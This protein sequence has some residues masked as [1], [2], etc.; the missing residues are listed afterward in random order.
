MSVIRPLTLDFRH[1][2]TKNRNMNKALKTLTMV[3][4]GFYTSTLLISILGYLLTKDIETSISPKTPLGIAISSFVI[5]YLLISIPLA[6]A[7][8]Y[9]M[10]QKWK[11]I[12]DE[13]SKMQKY[14]QGSIMRLSLIGSALIISVVS[15]FFMRTDISLIYCAGIA[16]IALIFTKP[17]LRKISAELDLENED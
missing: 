13:N 16:A 2:D 6:L 12:E 11:S 15:F 4:Y 14:T 5:L 7:G 8:F 1:L 10:L 3:Y 9:R 17:S